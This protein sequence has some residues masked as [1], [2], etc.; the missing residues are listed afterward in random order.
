MSLDSTP[1]APTPESLKPI[2][3]TEEALRL[4]LKPQAGSSHEAPDHETE[5]EQ[6]E[7][8]DKAIEARRIR[9]SILQRTG[10]KSIA[11]VMKLE[12]A[13]DDENLED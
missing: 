4:V 12:A 1:P 9:Y 8:L 6:W 7:A 11:E 2:P 5:M 10:A 13:T 3:S